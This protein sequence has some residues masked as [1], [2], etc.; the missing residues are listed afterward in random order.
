MSVLSMLA[1]LDGEGKELSSVTDG[2][3]LES[4]KLIYSYA[5]GPN[6]RRGEEEDFVL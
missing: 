6:K 1:S 3:I 2:I 5:E 4:F